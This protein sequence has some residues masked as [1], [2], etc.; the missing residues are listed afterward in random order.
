MTVG[1]ETQ[2]SVRR[3]SPRASGAT[4]FLA[5][6][7]AFVVIAA[8]GVGARGLIYAFTAAALVVLS[9]IDI[10]RRLLPDV[11]VLPSTAL[12]LA[13][14]LLYFPEDWLEWVGASAGAALLFWVIH[15]VNRSGLGMGDVKLAGLLGAA[16]GLDVVPAL[17]LGS[18]AA[19]LYGLA[20][21]VRHGTS[22]RKRTLPLGPFLALGA[23]VVLLFG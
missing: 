17:F 21:V 6:L 2:E 20:L 22:A 10:N 14:Q 5:T 16:L 12:I 11:I 13:A 9:A 4:A 3:L 8:E 1:V 18:L 15:L 23:I 19:A 7:I